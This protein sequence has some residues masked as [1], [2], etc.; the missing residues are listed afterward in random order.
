MSCVVCAVNMMTPDAI[1][2]DTV[3]RIYLLINCEDDFVLF[4]YNR[5]S[6]SGDLCMEY[7]QSLWYIVL[8]TVY[9]R[10]FCFTCSV[11]KSS[12]LTNSY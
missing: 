10:I 6:V 7:S 1:Q 3:L 11:Y 2:G 4:N 9:C 5:A 8:V 12:T